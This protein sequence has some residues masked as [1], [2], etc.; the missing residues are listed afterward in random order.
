MYFH[1]CK[2]QI[3]PDW[4]RTCLTILRRKFVLVLGSLH[5]TAM[6]AL[7]IWM[8]SS[9]FR[10]EA[11]QAH[12]LNL[13]A[14]MIPLPCTNTTLFGSNTPLTSMA[15]NQT[16]LVFY[17]IF[18][19]PCFNLIVPAVFFLVLFMRYDNFFTD[20]TTLR[21]QKPSS[22]YHTAHHT[23]P[24]T[25]SLFANALI[26]LITK[27]FA[28][29]MRFA[30]DVWPIVTGLLVLLTINIVFIVDI[31]TTIHRAIP[32]QNANDESRWTFGQTLALLLLVLPI[33]DVFDYIKESREAEYA[34][35]CTEKLKDA[36]K[37]RDM[38]SLRE[39]AK[40]AD[41]VHAYIKGRHALSCLDRY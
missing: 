20:S 12:R 36:V 34:R 33:R 17:S 1:T 41:N 14:E 16:S 31:E 19:A 8:W 3:P 11:T 26:C 2:A 28:R 15:L 18:L 9:P 5:L 6:A 23:S 22:D 25:R 35:K 40:R 30:K 4:T 7:G 13:T 10:Y 37:R 24:N 29:Y 21:K 39:A 38:K 32:Y 27:T